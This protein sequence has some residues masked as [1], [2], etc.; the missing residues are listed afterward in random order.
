MIV[1]RFIEANRRLCARVMAHLPQ[2]KVNFETLYLDVMGQLLA[3]QDHDVILDLGGGRSSRLI[4]VVEKE[5]LSSVVA[6]DVSHQELA[7]NEAIKKKCVVDLTE[8]LPFPDNSISMMTSRSVLEHLDDVEAFLKHSYRVL[9]PEGMCVHFF[10]S[11]NAPFALVNRVLPNAVT[12]RLMHSIYE[13][14][15]GVCGFPTHY[16]LCSFLAY[17]KKS[18]EL[19]FQLDAYYCSYHQSHYYSFFLPVFLCFAVYDWLMFKADLKQGCAYLLFV[20][21]KPL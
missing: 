2:A 11:R 19:G 17:R 5:R 6:I 1:R 20:L 15:K 9:K 10:P 21:R 7:I 12:K 16:D 18:E 14:S 13:E 4:Q 3:E 8:G